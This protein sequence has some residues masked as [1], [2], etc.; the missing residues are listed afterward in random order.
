SL[1]FSWIYDITPGGIKKTEPEGAEKIPIVGKELKTYK[2]TTFFSVLIIFSL[3]SF[4]IVDSVASRKIKSLDK[5][6]AVIPYSAFNSGNN[7]NENYYFI[8][9]QINSS[10]S[11]IKSYIII[12][13]KSTQR[14]LRDEKLYSEIG[15]DLSASFLVEYHPSEI[16]NQKQ[17]TIGLVS[18]KD[19][20]LLWSKN[21]IMKESWLDICKY[22]PEIS[23]K[24]ARKL[25]TF[26][27]ME[28]R[29]GIRE[30]PVSTMA[31]LYSYKGNFLIQDTWERVQT[32]N[33][34]IDSISFGKAIEYY[35][36]AIELDS[37]FAVA[38][39]NRAKA[40]TWAIWTGSIDISQ[41]N[42]CKKD[43]NKALQINPDLP[44][45]HVA[46]G[47]YYYYGKN[48]YEKAKES[49]NRAVEIKQDDYEC[50]FYLSLIERRIGNWDEVKLLSDRICNASYQNSS[51]FLTNIGITYVYLHDYTKAIEC[52]NKAIELM[53]SWNPPY[54]HKLRSFLLTGNI[55]NARDIAEEAIGKTGEPNRRILAELDM[56]EG[57][58]VSAIN[59]IELSV[60]DEFDEGG[61]AL[62]LK[63]KIYKNAGYDLRATENY[64]SALEYY[65]E[66]LSL[67]PDNAYVY[68]KIGIAYA[69]LN[70]GREA[71]Y[72][73]MKALEISM[74]YRDAMTEP[75]SI[76]DLALIYAMTGDNNS[77]YELIS[78]LTRME[79]PFSLELM[80]LDPDL[81]EI[82]NST[83]F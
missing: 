46:L 24:I 41:L 62:L 5:K 38:Y 65:S 82:I 45:A 15:S 20:R 80:S 36:H 12:P 21:Y 11:K 50:L 13:W 47:F 54:I 28:E 32:G 31:E 81:K 75:A 10:L 51:L 44:E 19:E 16:D 27:S 7:N 22:T 83:L 35:T 61:E 58:Y 64:S 25:R 37:T 76:Y 40:R 48:D 71:I 26:L 74:I 70:S 29:A 78:G 52:Y 72:Y 55:S 79:S 9:N 59:N 42:Q 1:W 69:G 49:F 39:A 73:G 77:S 68:S 3:L 43:I 2:A 67:Y 53:P 57:N 6:I 33:E 17:V 4:N 66:L 34:L 18:T 8:G 23:K 56:Y 14:Y 30:Q 60:K 63:A